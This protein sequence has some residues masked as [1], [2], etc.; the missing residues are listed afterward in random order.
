MT[1]HMYMPEGYIQGREENLYFTSD[2]RRIERAKS[3]GVILE[4][5]VTKCDSGTMDLTV[6]VGNFKGIIPRDEVVLSRDGEAVKD[7]AIITRVGKSASF[8]VKDIIEGDDGEPLIILSRRDA[9]RECAKEYISLLRPGDVIPA[10]V[11]HLEPFGAFVDIGCGIVSLLTVDTISVSRISHPRDRFRCGDRIYC[12]VRSIDGDTGRIYMS[13]RELL[14]T[15][16]ENA[17]DFSISQT[18]TG[19]VRSIENYG[20]FVE[21][22]PNLAGLAEYREGVEIGDVCAVYI[23]NIIPERMKIKLVI[24]DNVKGT[25][26][27]RMK[28]Y[29]DAE[30]VRHISSWRYS[31]LSSAKV[32]ES[33]F[34]A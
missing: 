16:E 22:A 33:V 10:T 2:I 15:W 6:N 19:V 20:I 24:I 32:V 7:I 1:D 17:A 14:G 5:T 21:L 9:Q 30:K 13:C 23:K 3:L 4:G 31:P 34:D 8:K 12:V 28:Y 29:I 26:E 11:T 27:Q 25:C 18:V